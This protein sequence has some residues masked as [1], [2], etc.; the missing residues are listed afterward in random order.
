MLDTRSFGA[1]AGL[2][3]LWAQF[4]KQNANWGR[5]KTMGTY[6]TLLLYFTLW[7]LGPIVQQHVSSYTVAKNTTC[8]FLL[9]NYPSTTLRDV[10]TPQARTF[11]TVKISNI[12]GILQD[13]IF[14]RPCS[15]G[16]LFWD[17]MFWYRI[18]GS[19]SFETT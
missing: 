11:T 8:I 12:L 3:S 17:I 18:T 6:I 7:F 1:R 9:Y 15:W 14:L 2:N 4:T 16:S 13:F 10:I 19:R 5:H